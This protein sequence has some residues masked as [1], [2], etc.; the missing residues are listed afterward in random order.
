M[1]GK[2]TNGSYVTDAPPV[3]GIEIDPWLGWLVLGV[4]VYFL[5]PSLVRMLAI[6][7]IEAA[8]RWRGLIVGFYRSSASSAR[9]VWRAA[10]TSEADADT[11]AADP[12]A[13][14]SPGADAADP[15]A[16]DAPRTDAATARPAA[17][18]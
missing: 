8:M 15:G 5:A 2:P 1:A 17:T 4:L 9:R 14:D 11:N 12:N 16:K 7:I 13:K 3:T 6:W 10:T 18:F